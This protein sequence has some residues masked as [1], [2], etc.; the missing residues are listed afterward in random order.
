MK[1]HGTTCFFYPYFAKNDAYVAHV[2]C[3]VSTAT[4]HRVRTPSRGGPKQLILG[5][6]PGGCTTHTY[7]QM[8][9]LGRLLIKQN[10]NGTVRMSHALGVSTPPLLM[11]EPGVEGG[12]PPRSEVELTRTLAGRTY[13]LEKDPH[14]LHGSFER[15]RSKIARSDSPTQRSPP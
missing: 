7:H 10:R 8:S 5:D 3:H 11:A 1:S 14:D 4:W 6:D 9:S 15:F 13:T 12:I 2:D